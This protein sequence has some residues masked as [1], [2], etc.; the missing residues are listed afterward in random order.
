MML[1]QGQV[2]RR[3]ERIEEAYRSAYSDDTQTLS[4]LIAFLLEI[5][6][7]MVAPARE[8][9]AQG[10]CHLCRHAIPVG[11]SHYDTVEHRERGLDQT[12]IYHTRTCPDC[13][14]GVPCHRAATVLSGGGK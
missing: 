1:T 5:L 2:R 3:L 7:E 8:P 14:E 11:V 10:W 12:A 9:L 4:E 13:I 6:P